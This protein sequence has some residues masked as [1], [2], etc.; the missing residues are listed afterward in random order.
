M[1]TRKHFEAIAFLFRSAYCET[2][3]EA[4][5][6]RNL[7]ENMAAMFKR[8]NPRFDIERFLTAC[9]FDN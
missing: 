1:M 6:V 8:E 3:H 2:E 5:T 4:E 9:G 7:A